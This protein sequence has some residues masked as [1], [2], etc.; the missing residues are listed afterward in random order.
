VLTTI[1]TPQATAVNQPLCGILG[2]I[3]R[4]IPPAL[5]GADLITAFYGRI[6]RWIVARCGLLVTPLS[7]PISY[8]LAVVLGHFTRGADEQ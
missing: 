2:E 1:V 4:P 8:L 5:T 3:L 7:R 6:L